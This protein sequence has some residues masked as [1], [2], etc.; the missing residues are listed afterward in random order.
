MLESYAP[1]FKHLYNQMPTWKMCEE[2]S[3]CSK[4]N[5]TVVYQ[6]N[7]S[8]CLKGAEYWCASWD[9]AKECKVI[10]DLNK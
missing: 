8:G 7:A 5:A 1:S 2:L 3:L 10:I 6:H 4:S 9:N